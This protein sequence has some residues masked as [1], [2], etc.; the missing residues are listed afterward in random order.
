ME[1]RKLGEHRPSGRK[2]LIMAQDILLQHLPEI[3]QDPPENSEDLK[4][5]LSVF[6][7]I[8][9]ENLTAENELPGL[10]Q[11]IT[12]IPDIFNCHNTPND[13]LP[14]LKEWVALEYFYDLSNEKKRELID[15]IVPLYAL[16]GTKSYLEKI[17]FLLFTDSEVT[18]N[19]DPLPSMQ[20]GI[21]RIGIES[22]LGGDIPFYF[23]VSLRFPN[24]SEF[25]SKWKNDHDHLWKRVC[26]IIDLAK[27][28]H[29]W[30]E[31]DFVFGDKKKNE[32]DTFI[33]IVSS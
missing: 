8:L 3:Y 7:K 25:Y 18:V 6:D 24:N 23:H 33:P 2:E 20:I 14:W 5:L 26:S 11:I 30:Y 32:A 29:T 12:S 21:S 9:F 1:N 15:S 19:D 28:A 27:P 10:E 13:F 22:R 17:L 4:K 16:R 31:L